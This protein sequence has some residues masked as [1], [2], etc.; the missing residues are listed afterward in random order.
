MNDFKNDTWKVERIQKTF[1]TLNS[2]ETIQKNSEKQRKSKKICF[3]KYICIVFSILE[4]E[5][6]MRNY[7]NQLLE[8]KDKQLTYLTNGRKGLR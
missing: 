6:T 3:F 7:L 8:K 2:F 1:K 4:E 5:N